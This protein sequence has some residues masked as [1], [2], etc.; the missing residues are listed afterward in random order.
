M[1]A[2]AGRELH[3]LRFRK[4]LLVRAVPV[5]RHAF[6]A[7]THCYTA[8]EAHFVDCRGPHDLTLFFY[9]V[10]F[11]RMNNAHQVSLFGAGDPT[12]DPKLKGVRRRQIGQRAWVDHLDGWL[13]GTNSFTTGLLKAATGNSNGE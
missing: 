9:T 13:G 11:E 1:I 6:P 12:F 10:F 4:R 7:E 5:Q 8:H 2:H 3:A